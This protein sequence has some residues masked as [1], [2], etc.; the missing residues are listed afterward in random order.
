MPRDVGAYLTEQQRKSSGDVATDWGQIEELYNKKLWHQLTLKLLKFVKT[1]TFSKGDGLVKMYENFIADFEHRINP[2]ALAEIMV[3]IVK[4][5]TDIDT[6]VSFIE[7]MKEKVKVSDEAKALCLTTLGTI[8]LRNRDFPA[9]KTVVEEC[10]GLLN[11]LDGV[12]TV[13]G[14][15]YELSS[16]YHKLMGNHA[17]Y[18]QE[19]LRFLGC[20]N[21]NDMPASEQIERAFNLGL[22]A[23]L[24][25]GVYNFGELLAHPILES[26]KSTDKAWLTELLYTFN[27]GNIP[28]FDE[29]KK[30]W[31][32]QP[33]LASNELHMRQKISLLCL[34]EMTFQRPATNRQLTFHEIADETQLPN[35]EVEMLVMKALSL[36]LVK[37]SIDEIDQKVHMTWV[38]PRVLD[39]QQIATMQKRLEQWTEDVSGMEQLLEVK[40]KDI[41]T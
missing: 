22:A 4:Q 25:D 33:D 28:K 40:A 13:H 30:I 34:M 29:L 8:R 17:L 5:M 36:G 7:K 12:T 31:A 1:P 32:T 20:T 38:Q 6:A 26:L 15:F 23:I 21:M 18:Y 3:Y 2:L 27:S 10:S 16:N 9:T 14:R 37:G 24:G 41:L 19:A 35:N 39:L 11:N